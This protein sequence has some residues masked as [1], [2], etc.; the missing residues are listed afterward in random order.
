MH[1]SPPELPELMV[2]TATTDSQ[3]SERC[4]NCDAMTPHQ[5]TIEIVTE[6]EKD[7]NAAFSREP[8]RVT[9]CQQCGTT[10][11]QRANDM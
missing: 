7:S 10:T 5:I 1:C 11:K 8:Y 6:S 4:D 9:E 2:T 3:P